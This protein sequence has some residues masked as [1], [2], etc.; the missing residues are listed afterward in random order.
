MHLSLEFLS[1]SEAVKNAV[2][3][4]RT[5]WEFMRLY[6][7]IYLMQKKCC[8]FHSWRSNGYIVGELCRISSCW[9]RVYNDF[10]NVM[11][12]LHVDQTQQMMVLTANHHKVAESGWALHVNPIYYIYYMLIIISLW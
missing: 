5:Y 6:R 12:L 1:S 3:K 11:L 7:W 8:C 2:K 4:R 9:L 10:Y